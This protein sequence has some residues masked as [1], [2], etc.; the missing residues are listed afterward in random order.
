[1]NYY[2]HNYD[3]T[4]DNNKKFVT[5]PILDCPTCTQLKREYS[6]YTTNDGNKTQTCSVCKWTWSSR[7]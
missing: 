6:M 3:D 4:R 1:M 7:K 2:S 5:Y